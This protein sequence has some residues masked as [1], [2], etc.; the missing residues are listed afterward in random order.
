[1]CGST[2][3]KHCSAIIVGAFDHPSKLGRHVIQFLRFDRLDGALQ[4]NFLNVFSPVRNAIE[5]NRS[6]LAIAAMI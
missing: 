6:T 2:F 5:I 3:D 4:F 1:M